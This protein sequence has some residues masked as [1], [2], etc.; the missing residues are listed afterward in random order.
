VSGPELPPAVLASADQWLASSRESFALPLANVRK[1]M[2]APDTEAQLANV[3]IEVA[4]QAV[5]DAHMCQG[6]AAAYVLCLYELARTQAR[7][8]ALEAKAPPW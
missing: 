8:E 5:G 6:L 4:A 3:A 2:A 1:A 7:L